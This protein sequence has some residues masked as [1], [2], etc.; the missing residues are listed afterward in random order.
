MKAS[1]VAGALAFAVS[2]AAAPSKC[3]C[4]TNSAQPDGTLGSSYVSTSLLVPIAKSKPNYAF[5][6]TK[7]AKVTPNDV[8]TI[9]NLDLPVAQTQGKVC[10][11]VFDFPSKES[12]LG[13][14]EFK[15]KGT[16]NFTGYAIGAGAV[17]GQTTYNK[18][19]APGPSPPNPPP[20][21]TP[22]HSYIINSAP[23]GIPADVPGSVTVS[24]SLCSPDTNFVFE[25]NTKG[26]PLGFF[27]V[28]TD[29]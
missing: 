22:G 16:F 23:C 18:Q 2:A 13:K 10:N 28:L 7:L 3:A 8:C 20:I 14:F 17:A 24:G 12:A 6:A 15:G 29:I 4:P 1:T 19:P 9:F 25:E 21:M 5:P 11:L 27:V 26:C